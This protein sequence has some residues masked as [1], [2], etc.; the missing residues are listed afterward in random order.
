MS[1]WDSNSSF[2]SWLCLDCFHACVYFKK[3]LLEQIYLWSLKWTLVLTVS[4]CS[5]SFIPVF[6]ILP[7]PACPARAL[8]SI[9]LFGVD[10]PS[11]LISYYT[12]KLCVCKDFSL[13]FKDLTAKFH[14]SIIYNIFFSLVLC[15]LTQDN[16][17][18][19][20][21]VVDYFKDVFVCP[22]YMHQGFPSM[23]VCLMLLDSQELELH[24]VV[25]CHLGLRN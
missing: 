5:L 22:F 25:S 4:L 18:L 7:P 11:S 17:K 13:L 12:H 19:F 14:I 9:S 1:R 21:I 20:S 24:K 2:I 23:Y 15:Y 3:L 10:P 6:P 16:M 8:C